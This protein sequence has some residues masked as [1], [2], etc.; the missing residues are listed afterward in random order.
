MHAL[1]QQN[2]QFSHQII[3]N[4]I[5]ASKNIDQPQKRNKSDV[6]GNN[7]K[8]YNFQQE[9]VNNIARKKPILL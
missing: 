8:D 1:V 2:C 4:Q 9:Q 5:L 7:L 6:T 3:S